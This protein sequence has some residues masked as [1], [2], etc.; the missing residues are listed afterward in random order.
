MADRTHSHRQTAAG[1]GPAAD[2]DDPNYYELLGVA[3]SA[4]TA[5]IQRAYRAAMKQAHPDRQHSAR[6]A[7][8]EEHARLLNRAYATLSKPDAR[9]RYDQ[10]IRAQEVQ[11]QIMRRYVAGGGP[12]MQRSDTAHLR[13]TMTP[14]QRREQARANRNALIS[15]LSAFAVLTAV[16]LGL[17]LLYAAAEA[18]LRAVL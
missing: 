9:R 18:V 16:V 5:D 8:A 6:R 2:A 13:H 10:S 17:V 4:T 1:T 11:D 3:F 7:R 12:Q 14:A 15:L